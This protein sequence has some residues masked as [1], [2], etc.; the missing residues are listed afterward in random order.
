MYT[1]Y[2]TNKQEPRVSNESRSLFILSLLSYKYEMN[3]FPTQ[4]VINKLRLWARILTSICSS[5]GCMFPFSS[6]LYS[7]VLNYSRF[8]DWY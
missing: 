1:T 4:S 2:I 7:Y 8:F 3:S 6:L 5:T